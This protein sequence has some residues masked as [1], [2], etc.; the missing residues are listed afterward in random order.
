MAFKKRC[1]STAVSFG[2]ALPREG[3]EQAAR[4]MLDETGRALQSCHFVA[5]SALSFW[6]S[7]LICAC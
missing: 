5:F 3:K 4:V 7:R 1:L 2:P 6:A